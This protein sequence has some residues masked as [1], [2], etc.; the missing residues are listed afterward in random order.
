MKQGQRARAKGWNLC[1]QICECKGVI[2]SPVN[3]FIM[4]VYDKE[5]SRCD[6]A[7]EFSH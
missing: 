2:V 6:I 7:M 3:I 1:L 4:E 5:Q